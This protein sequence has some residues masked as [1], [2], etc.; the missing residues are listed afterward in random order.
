MIE[1][2]NN[3]VLLDGKELQFN[4]KIIE[5]AEY[6]GK[7]VIVFETDEDGGYDNVF[8]YTQDFQLLWRIKTAPVVIG[9]TARSPYVGVDIVEGNCRAIDFYG[10]RFKVNLENGEI[11]S[12]D[13]VRQYF[14][15]YFRTP[16]NLQLSCVY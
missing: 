4:K 10:R 7:V 2:Q 12:K 11:I 13:I 8:C 5:A 3:K 16:N 14:G 9:G 6:E 1:T 15:I